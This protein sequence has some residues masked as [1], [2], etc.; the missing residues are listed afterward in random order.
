MRLV[1]NNGEVRI[2]GVGRD[3]ARI[4]YAIEREGMLDFDLE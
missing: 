3:R 4:A 1:E 2:E